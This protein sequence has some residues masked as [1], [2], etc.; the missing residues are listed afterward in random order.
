A[1]VDGC[2][3]GAARGG[4]TTSDK[5]GG[6]DHSR[7]PCHPST[8]APTTL[9]FVEIFSVS[10]SEHRRKHIERGPR[11]RDEAHAERDAHE[12]ELGRAQPAHQSCARVGGTMI[13]CES[14]RCRARRAPCSSA[15]QS[16]QA[17]ESSPSALS[18]FLSSLISRLFCTLSR[19]SSAHRAVIAAM[20]TPS[21]YTTPSSIG[22]D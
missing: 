1:L 12:R 21:V 10:A 8:C 2:A 20:A 7:P 18:S 6:R 13:G 22:V 5:R 14:C 19:R 16:L 11:A 15:L 9:R 4:P 17:S 3:I